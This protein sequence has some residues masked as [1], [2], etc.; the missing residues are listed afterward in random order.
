MYPGVEIQECPLRV[1]KYNDSFFFLHV[2][3]ESINPL[4]LQLKDPMRFINTSVV[5]GFFWW[6]VFTT[7]RR[8]SEHNHLSRQNVVCEAERKTLGVFLLIHGGLHYLRGVE[9]CWV[10]HYVQ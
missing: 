2:P 6:W 8:C 3:A 1:F 10:A 5:I 9:A 4:K 7:G